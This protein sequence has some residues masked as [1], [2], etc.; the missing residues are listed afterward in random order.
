MA[1]VTLKQEI[2]KFGEVRDGGCIL[3]IEDGWYVMEVAQNIF[4][5]HRIL[6]DNTSDMRL[7]V[8]WKGFIE[9]NKL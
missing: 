1:N 9:N 3:R 7:E 8:H 6:V 4:N 5:R 2:E